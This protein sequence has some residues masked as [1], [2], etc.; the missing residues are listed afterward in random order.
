MELVRLI[1]IAAVCALFAAILVGRALTGR[2]LRA[3]RRGPHPRGRTL[4][5]R[6][7][8]R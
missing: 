3:A 4:T 7:R 6:P 1:V 8:P 2:R 5:I